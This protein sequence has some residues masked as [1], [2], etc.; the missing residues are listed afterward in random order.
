M[1]AYD[2]VTYKSKGR[3]LSDL[4]KLMDNVEKRSLPGGKITPGDVSE[5]QVS[6]KK[7]DGMTDFKSAHKAAKKVEHDNSHEEYAEGDAAEEAAETPEFEDTEVEGDEEI[8]SDRANPGDKSVPGKKVKSHEFVGDAK[9]ADAALKHF[10]VKS[11][12]HKGSKF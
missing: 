3:A 6:R 9:Q 11:K 1:A 2:H 4:S 5:V 12:K 8:H 10:L 7:K